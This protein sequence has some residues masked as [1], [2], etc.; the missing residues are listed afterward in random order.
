MLGFFV[1]VFLVLSKDEF[2]LGIE[3]PVLQLVDEYAYKLCQSWGTTVFLGWGRRGKK[4][5]IWG[6][7]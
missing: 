1:N 4:E 3:P 7:V 6:K 2:G 5:K